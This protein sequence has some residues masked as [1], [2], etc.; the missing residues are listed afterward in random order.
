MLD[1]ATATKRSPFRALIVDDL[2][3]LSRDIGDTH[4]IVFC[5]LAGAGVKLVDTSGLDSSHDSAEMTITMG[6]IINSQYVK[7]IARQTHRGLT[8][9]A[10]AGFSTG[11]SLYG[12]R[13]I[14][15]LNP[16]DPE[17]ARKL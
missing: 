17:H 1:V 15:E 6:S 4:S 12:Y 9:R 5:D 13:T 16:T 10:L 11:G 8:G 7:N 2:S 14:G 3:R